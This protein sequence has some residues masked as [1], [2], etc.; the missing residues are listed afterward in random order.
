MFLCIMK[1]LLK[2][3]TNDQRVGIMHEA[4]VNFDI[5]KTQRI[6]RTEAVN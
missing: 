5:M 1:T 2:R 6:E 3:W 4:K